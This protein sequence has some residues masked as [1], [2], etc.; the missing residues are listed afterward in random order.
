MTDALIHPGC[1]TILNQLTVKEYVCHLLKMADRSI[2]T[3]KITK[4]GFLLR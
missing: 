4:L 1:K 3:Q 2:F